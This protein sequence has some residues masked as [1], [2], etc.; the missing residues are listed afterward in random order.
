MG[1]ENGRFVFPRLES[2]STL[3][4]EIEFTFH[5][6]TISSLFFAAFG[7]QNPQLTFILHQRQMS[8]N[9]RRQ[10]LPSVSHPIACEHMETLDEQE[11]SKSR[12]M[13][14][15]AAEANSLVDNK[16]TKAEPC[17]N[18]AATID[19]NNA[20][21]KAVEEW[22]SSDEEPPETVTYEDRIVGLNDVVVKETVVLSEVVLDDNKF[23]E[24]QGDSNG[25]KKKGV[26]RQLKKF[27]KGVRRRIVG[28][29]KSKPIEEHALVDHNQEP[30]PSTLQ[31]ESSQPLTYTIKL[32][33][34]KLQPPDSAPPPIPTSSPPHS[35]LFET[36]L[37]RTPELE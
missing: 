35:P 7:L 17:D 21:L 27:G 2:Q 8:L 26:L 15:L 30:Q 25:K 1:I 3:C 6:T 12:S 19:N 28:P 9:G 22:K 5:S 13:D 37:F 36:K 23:N 34:K 14:D 16:P 11:E 4:V 33:R 20:I 24:D 29:K 31:C 10:R 32:T 18:L